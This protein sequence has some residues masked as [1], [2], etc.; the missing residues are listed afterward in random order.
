MTQTEQLVNDLRTALGP[1]L[2]SVV[3]YGSAAA[4]DFVPGI[5]AHDVLIVVEPLGALQL[6]AASA[7]LA[8]W[9]QA[10]N[11]HPQ[12][13]TPQEL[14][15]SADV[16][17][18]EI[19]DMQQSHRV[20][21]GPDPLSGMKIDVP[22]YRIQLEREL[23]TR[24]LQLRRQYLACAGEEQRIAR[25]MVASVSTFLVLLRAA[26]RLYNDSVPSEKI[27]ALDQLAAHI[28]FDPEPFRAVLSLKHQKPKPPPGEMQT[29]FGKYLS[30]IDHVVHAVDRH[31]HASPPNSEKSHG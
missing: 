10:G 12:L 1:S 6:A 22:H 7:A 29:L 16:F 20:L 28:P 4:G 30:S 23:K 21:F 19:A 2:K 26:L 24:L 15:S 11:P 3:L 18:I 31:L 17:P 14:Q 5:S 25:L 9:E 27:Q 8:W 13:F